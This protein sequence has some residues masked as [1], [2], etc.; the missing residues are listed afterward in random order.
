MIKLIVDNNGSRKDVYTY[1]KDI[2]IIGSDEYSD[3]ILLGG[4]V[5][6]THLEIMK[7]NDRFYAINRANDPF[8]TVNGLPFGKKNIH[9][10]DIIQIGPYTIQ[11]EEISNGQRAEQEEEAG[12]QGKEKLSVEFYDTEIK[13]PEILENAIALKNLTPQTTSLF[14]SP[15]NALIN[16]PAAEENA[17]AEE[18]ESISEENAP[19]EE[20][21]SNEENASFEENTPSEEHPAPAEEIAAENFEEELDIEALMREVEQLE[22]FEEKAKRESEELEESATEKSVLP[23]SQTLEE[24]K[25]NSPYPSIEYDEDKDIGTWKSDKGDLAKPP[26]PALEGNGYQWSFWIGIT[27]AILTLLGLV[28]SAIYVHMM[29]KSE[30]EEI[31]AAE[32]VADVSMALKYAQIHHIKPH[33]QNWSDPEFLKNSLTRILPHEYPSLANIDAHGQFNNTPY[34]LRLYTSGDFSQFLVIAQPA[35]S[36]L[37]WLIPKSAIVVDSRIMEMRKISDF[38]SLNRLLVST[39]NLEGENA[40]EITQLVKQGKLIPLSFLVHKKRDHEFSPPKTL[41]IIRPGAENLIYN[42]PRY[43]QVGENIM[44][45][46]V[47]LMEMSGG[48]HEISR[49]KQEMGVI[50]EMPNF[51][52]YSSKGMEFAMEA[53]KALSVIVP[54]VKFL[55]AYLTLSPKGKMGKSH[56]LID[57]ENMQIAIRDSIVEKTIAMQNSAPQ[58]EAPAIQ[59][60]EESPEEFE[61]PLHFQLTALATERQ[62]ALREVTDLWVQ[63]L[64][65]HVVSAVPHFSEKMGDIIHRYQQVLREQHDKFVHRILELSYES[66]EMP[67]SRFMKYIQAAGLET[68]LQEMLRLM[69]QKFQD[70]RTTPDQIEFLRDKIQKASNFI[71]LDKYVVEVAALLT[72]PR[73]PNIDMLID[74]QDKVHRDVIQTLNVFLIEPDEEKPEFSFSDQDRTALIHALKTAW[75]NDEEEFEFYLSEFDNLARDHAVTMETN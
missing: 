5:Q 21:G 68:S 24:K 65:D 59:K 55:T 46:A 15:S 72:I 54:N 18:H 64:N 49:L 19:A 20:N 28:L 4:S 42:A 16:P 45:R 70:Q 52:V 33:K 41:A 17:P 50:A 34:I 63:L 60:E 9:T 53:Q 3:L 51:V 31:K 48:S 73:F 25:E 23:A 22:L 30:E 43:Y 66:Q 62:K 71:E 36:M 1:D 56:L 7:Q 40:Q 29:E 8:A 38:R 11:F 67:V 26:T 35:P 44:E 14:P 12:G 61:H 10:D 37:Q 47:S 58:F 6:E 69:N 2:I 75:M 57:D 13:L 27:I 74:Y 39:D 32:G